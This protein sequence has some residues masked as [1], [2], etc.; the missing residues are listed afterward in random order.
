MKYTSIWPALRLASN[1][2]CA[3]LEF[4]SVRGVA[5][6]AGSMGARPATRALSQAALLCVHG[7]DCSGVARWLC[8]DSIMGAAS[9]G[10]LIWL[11]A[12]QMPTG[13]V[14]VSMKPI[15]TS[16][17]TLMRA[18]QFTVSKYSAVFM[19]CGSFTSQNG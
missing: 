7:I 16:D 18:A 14:T 19:T 5:T 11:N 10:A 1:C 9:L 4:A 17:G 3:S 15:A 8:G 12:A 13:G 2:S 6:L